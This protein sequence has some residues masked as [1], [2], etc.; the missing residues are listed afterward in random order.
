MEQ[1]VYMAGT[2]LEAGH[3]VQALRPRMVVS[4]LEPNE[5]LN[6]AKPGDLVLFYSEHFD[7]FREAC[8]ELQRRRVATLYLLDGILEWRNAWENRSEEPACPWTM[9]PV[10]SD[11]AACIGQSQAR[12][13]ASWGNFRRLEIIGVPRFDQQRLRYLSGKLKPRDEDGRF[14]LLVMTAKC[15]GFTP[16]QVEI[17]KRSLRDLRDNFPRQL[18]DGRTVEVDWRLTAG[19]EQELQVANRLND[20]SGRELAEILLDYDAVIS[21]PST[22]GLEAMLAGRPLAWLDYHGTPQLT[23]AAWSIGHRDDIPRV[24]AELGSPPASK[25]VWQNQ[26]LRDHVY[27][28]ESATERLTQLVQRMLEQAKA[29]IQSGNPFRFSDGMLAPPRPVENC[30]EHAELY[31][32][33]KE[34]TERELL[35]AQTEWAHAR[36][37]ISHLQAELRQA[38]SELADAHAI[39]E[40][41]QKHPLAGPIVRLRQKLIDHWRNWRK[42][43]DVVPAQAGVSEQGTPKP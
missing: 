4:C 24:L 27:L 13:L 30:F 32:A 38:R 40:E 39:F 35:V 6:V 28:A 8:I 7:R 43:G 21:T 31:P 12:V 36:R 20:L 11:V 9:R 26:L 22:A 37:E 17:T 34:F 42:E 5:L 18:A 15:P 2:E 3:H 29:D 14:R 25:V 33:F 16:G 41:I 23:P 1:S 19:L 10:I